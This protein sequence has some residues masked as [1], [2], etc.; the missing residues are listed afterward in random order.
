MLSAHRIQYREEQSCR[1][2]TNEEVEIVMKKETKRIPDKKYRSIKISEQT[3]FEFLYESFI[4]NQ[5][6]FFDVSDKNTSGESSIVTAFDI[7]WN[8]K[9]F[10]CVARNELSYD[11][12]LQFPVIDTK[13]LLLKL[14]DTTPSL[15]Q[16]ERFIGYRNRKLQI[17]NAANQVIIP[18][19][20]L[21]YK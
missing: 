2:D 4:D 5:N 21:F 19:N 10:F 11:E 12:Q 14:K 8:T 13:V 15:Y 9:E 18:S 6:R 7:D 16:G 3:L 1:Q 20:H 17:Y